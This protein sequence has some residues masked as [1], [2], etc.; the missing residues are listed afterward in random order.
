MVKWLVD[1]PADC[2]MLFSE[3]K[4]APKSHGRPH[5][6]KLDVYGAI[7]DAV[8]KDDT[9]YATSYVSTPNKFRDS[10]AHRLEHLKSKYREYA[11][12]FVQTGN[13]IDHRVLETGPAYDNVLQ[14][15]LSEF[16]WFS[17][18]HGLWRAIPSYSAKPVTSVPGVCRGTQLLSL[19][20]KPM[21]AD[22][23]T[24]SS[25]SVTIAHSVDPIGLP[26]S[27]YYALPTSTLSQPAAPSSTHQLIV[28]SIYQPTPPS[29]D[30]SVSFPPSVQASAV[31]LDPDSL[32]GQ[33][34]TDHVIPDLPDLPDLPVHQASF[35]SFT[36]EVYSSAVPTPPPS[37][38]TFSV[39]GGK[40][41]SQPAQLPSQGSSSTSTSAWDAN[42]SSALSD[43]RSRSSKSGSRKR[44]KSDLEDR[45]K[46]FRESTEALQQNAAQATEAKTER[47]RMKLEYQ[48]HERECN[49]L[50]E[51]Q[52]V[53]QAN[54]AIV[55]QR[56]KE[57]KEADI[58]LV[59]AQAE[60]L[61]LKIE[62]AK[63][64]KAGQVE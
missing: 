1:H 23:T 44:I 43:A 4:N 36:G 64:E 20:Q 39:D 7:A 18:L 25:L 22:T 37:Q 11:A 28:P 16:P 27:N 55:F 9:K 21:A 2:V 52:M 46:S 42:S 13:G 51:Q 32:V 59:E 30:P 3:D 40:S 15:V 19:I 34:S 29:F 31:Q 24:D 8:F 17:D 26:P 33:P 12:R 61:R 47:I 35:P 5:S 53:E 58:R 57:K 56:E 14:R 49:L 6:T 48:R 10:V 38:T 60:V 41:H 50:R 45:V 63:L 62:L 54:A